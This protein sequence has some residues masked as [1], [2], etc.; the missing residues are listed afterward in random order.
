M[1]FAG[2]SH[3][4][5]RIISLTPLNTDTGNPCYASQTLV[6]GLQRGERING[7]LV[8]VTPSGAH[9]FRPSQAKGASRNFDGVLCDSASITHSINERPN[10][11]ALTGLFGDGKA[12]SY[13]IPGLKEVGAASI[14]DIITP[15][16]FADASISHTGD[17]LAW[18][19]PSEIALLNVFGAGLRLTPSHDRLFDPEKAKLTPPRPTISNLQWIAG[20]QYITPADMDILIGGPDRPPSKRM[21]AEMRDADIRA[22]DEVRLARRGSP[23]PGGGSL[24]D[25]QAALGA[26]HNQSAETWGAY[27]QRQINERTEQLGLTGDSMDRTAEDSKG[28][29]DEVSKYI[30]KQKRQ[31]ALG[32]IGSKFGL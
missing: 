26:T 5:G 28:F 9:L 4:E 27:M 19:G 16:R 12:R 29:S 7:V 21:L 20:T 11:T 32:F 3:F 18:T 24:R 14:P 22:R 10:S 15:K 17:I 23:A 30:A 6:G 13:S 25:R 2:A 31:V 1:T 8:A